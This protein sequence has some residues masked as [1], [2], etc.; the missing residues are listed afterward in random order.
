MP[1]RVKVWAIALRVARTLFL[2]LFAAAGTI[3]LVRYA[4]GFFSDSREMDAR[5]AQAARA[6]IQAEE[7]QKSP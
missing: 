5:Y 7:V 1:V 6:E 2:M 4:P 3:L